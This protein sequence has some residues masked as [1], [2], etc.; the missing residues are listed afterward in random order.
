MVVDGDSAYTAMVEACLGFEGASVLTVADLAE[1]AAAL[2]PD[3][4]GIVLQE[5]PPEAAAAELLL[6]VGEHC[7]TAPIVVC[8]AEMADLP[9]AMVWVERDDL[10]ALTGIL[11]LEP[12]HAH[13][14]TDRLLHISSYELDDDS[15]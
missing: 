14:P 5:V 4:T 1:A 3:V 6:L 2:R 7:P 13:V 8:T 10:A 9:A 11:G 15:C 12:E